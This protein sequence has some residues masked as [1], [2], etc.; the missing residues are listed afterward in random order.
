MD[1]MPKRRNCEKVIWIPMMEMYKSKSEHTDKASVQTPI[2]KC[3]NSSKL[4]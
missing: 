2:V 1:S 4:K 3:K